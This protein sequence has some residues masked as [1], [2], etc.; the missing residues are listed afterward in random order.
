MA[1]KKKD[2]TKIQKMKAA[3]L[4][5]LVWGATAITVAVLVSLIVTIVTVLT[6]FTETSDDKQLL[7]RTLGATKLQ[8]F[9]YV[10]LPANVATI[11]AALKISVSITMD[12]L[13]GTI[14]RSRSG[15]HGDPGSQPGP[16]ISI[17]HMRGS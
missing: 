3:A 13:Y 12:A 4:R 9:R 17:P 10:V 15:P 1:K 16:R 5:T 2:Y 14:G 6:G 8:I 11:V 7:M